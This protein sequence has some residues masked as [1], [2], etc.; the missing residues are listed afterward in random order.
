MLWIEPWSTLGC[1]A[2]G[3][4]FGSCLAILANRQTER[5]HL[6]MMEDYWNADIKRIESD[7]ESLRQKLSTFSGDK[8]VVNTPGHR[9][10]K[11]YNQTRHF[12]HGA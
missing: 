9:Q 10:G 4:I 11:S 3:A 12:T 8:H 5:F 1:A 2:I 6:N 7:L